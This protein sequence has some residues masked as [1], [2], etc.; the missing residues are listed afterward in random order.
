MRQPGIYKPLKDA[1][2]A[3]IE[4]SPTSQPSDVAGVEPFQ[5]QGELLEAQRTAYNEKQRGLFKEGL[6]NRDEWRSRMEHWENR[7]VVRIRAEHAAA[8]K[9]EANQ[10]TAA[11]GNAAPSDSNQLSLRQE[12]KEHEEF[13]GAKEMTEEQR[14]RF[15]RIMDR[16]SRS[17]EREAT[18]RANGSLERG[19]NERG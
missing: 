10:P 5:D 6:I 8:V 15:N 4:A 7:A 9:A 18:Q 16:G 1:T 2:Q 12:K 11:T 17:S 13:S 19:G 14:A 3:G